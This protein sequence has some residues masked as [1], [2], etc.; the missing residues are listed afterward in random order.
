MLI[1]ISQDISTYSLLETVALPT[2]HPHVFFAR[3]YKFMLMLSHEKW[4]C[5]L[6]TCASVSLL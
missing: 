3:L 4:K 6:S 5:K 2:F 1:I